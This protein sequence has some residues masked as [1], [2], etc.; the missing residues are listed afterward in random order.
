MILHH[1]VDVLIRSVMILYKTLIFASDVLE[2]HAGSISLQR[3][4]IRV[5]NF[6]NQIRYVIPFSIIHD[7]KYCTI[8]QYENE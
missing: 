2:K 4:Q 7:Y 3:I 6:R 8:I 5:Y 1:L